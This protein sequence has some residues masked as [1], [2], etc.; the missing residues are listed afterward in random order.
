MIPVFQR[1][2]DVGKG[3][4]FKCCLASIF[5]QEYDN[6]PNFI[7]F[8]KSYMDET[9]SQWLSTFG[10]KILRLDLR[11]QNS[12][13]QIEWMLASG[14]YCILSVDSQKY[15]GGAHAVVGQFIRN[16]NEYSLEVVHDPNPDNMK[17]KDFDKDFKIHSI[18]FFIS[19]HP[20][21]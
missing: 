1:I 12:I 16:K 10:Y 5:E 15:P 18:R 20:K 13:Y 14:I 3:D 4:C 7:E 6:I 19:T 21:L 17:Y 9:A 11:D 8:K 2:I